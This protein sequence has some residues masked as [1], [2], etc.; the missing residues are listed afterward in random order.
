WQMKWLDDVYITNL[1]RNTLNLNYGASTK[2][3]GLE[4]LI[5]SEFTI[6]SEELGIGTTI[7]MLV[8]HSNN[9]FSLFDFKTGSRFLDDSGTVDEMQ[10]SQLIGEII[11]DSKLD[12]GKMELMLRA[13]II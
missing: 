7:D 13:F 3:T 1:L 9:S 8:E 5:K 11:K 4:D 2:G 6:A 10:Y 12:K